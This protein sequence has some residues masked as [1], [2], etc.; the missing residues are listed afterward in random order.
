[1]RK[2]E[3]IEMSFMSGLREAATS[4]N[5]EAVPQRALKRPNLAFKRTPNSRPRNGITLSFTIA[6]PAVWSRLTL[7]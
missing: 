7:R 2:A 4:T 6:R 5:L 1:M 3:L